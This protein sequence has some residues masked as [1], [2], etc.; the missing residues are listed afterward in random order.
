MRDRGHPTP[1]VVN[2]GSNEKTLGFQRRFRG[3]SP[4]SAS[5]PKRQTKADGGVSTKASAPAHNRCI[6]AS[7]RVRR[8]RRRER[9]VTATTRV[10]RTRAAHQESAE[11]TELALS[12]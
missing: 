3:A 8:R 4:Y 2:C 1:S 9:A 6:V 5:N 12:L 11:Q 10:I 7:C